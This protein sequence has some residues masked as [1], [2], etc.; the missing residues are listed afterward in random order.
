MFLQHNNILWPSSIIIAQICTFNVQFKMQHKMMYRAVER[1]G[2]G[3]SRNYH[4]QTGGDTGWETVGDGRARQSWH[5]PVLF[6]QFSYSSGEKTTSTQHIDETMPLPNASTRLPR[7]LITFHQIWEIILVTFLYYPLSP[8]CQT[9][10][11]ILYSHI[12]SHICEENK[13]A[14]ASI[15]WTVLFT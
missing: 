11:S 14:P 9:F 2:C 15:P 3:C 1:R 13:D 5:R 12:K 6:C 4:S 7:S 10:S 8:H